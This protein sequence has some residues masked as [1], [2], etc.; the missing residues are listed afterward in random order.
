MPRQRSV[1]DSSRSDL[2]R[3]TWY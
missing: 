2:N 3:V 1:R